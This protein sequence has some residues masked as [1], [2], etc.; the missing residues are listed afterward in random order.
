MNRDTDLI[1]RALIDA[2]QEPLTDN[3]S[4]NKTVRWRTIELYYL[5]TV[6]ET[7][8]DAEWTCLKKRIALSI[9]DK[10]NLTKYAYAYDLPV[11]C[12]R[13]VEI[14]DNDEYIVEGN[15]LFTDTGSAEL[16]YI[17]NGKVSEANKL[18]DDDY[19]YYNPPDFE[20]KLQQCIETMLAAK[21]S[22]KITG[23]K[24]LYATLVT[25]ARGIKEDAMKATRSR[26]V[27]KQKGSVW[28]ADRMGISGAE[29][30]AD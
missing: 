27:S 20:P 3:D 15:I 4:K 2:G 6:L 24:Q 30:A 21:F 16:L 22:L 19:P 13:A 7:I 10:D 29:D 23:D 28:W 9:T 8:A 17:S 18:I 5:P 11:D 1:S 12:A 25:I 26:G 14:K